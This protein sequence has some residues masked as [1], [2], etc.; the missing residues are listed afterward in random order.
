MM[1]RTNDGL[2][3]WQAETEGID[4][5]DTTIGDFLDRRAQELPSQE[6]IVYSCYPE[7]GDALNLRWTYQDYRVRARCFLW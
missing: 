1:S 6:A 2:S 7:F 5:L 4:L 3:S